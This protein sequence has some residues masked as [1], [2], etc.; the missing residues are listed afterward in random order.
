L[1]EKD[2]AP[3]AHVL[4]VRGATGCAPT[5]AFSGRA[6]ESRG[7]LAGIA[8]DASARER[9]LRLLGDRGEGGGV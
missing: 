7:L 6:S 3:G 9:R 4:R 5:A 8:T 1:V 2:L